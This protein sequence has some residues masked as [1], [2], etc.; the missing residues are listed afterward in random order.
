MPLLSLFERFPDRI[1]RAQWWLGMAVIGAIVSGALALGGDH[2]ALI[3]LGAAAVSLAIFIPISIARLHDRNRSA[4]TVFSGLMAVALVANVFKRMLGA[5][6]KWWIFIGF[7]V[8][9]A[10]WAVVELGVLRGTIGR[11]PYGEDPLDESANET[12]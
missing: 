8:A 12:A 10:A 5:D 4:G 9:I 7:C 11:N 6:V 2:N 3:M 1:G